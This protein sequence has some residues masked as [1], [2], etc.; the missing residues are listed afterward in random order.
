MTCTCHE[1]GAACKPNGLFA[2]YGVLK[3]GNKICYD[4]CAKR[5]EQALMALSGKDKISLYLIGKNGQEEIINWP[6]TLRIK[7]R[8]VK[9]GRHNF[10][11][12]RRDVWFAYKGK[13]FHGTQY[14]E[15]NEVC[16]IQAVA[17]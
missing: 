6:G 12:S 4:C 11:G 10:A 8:Y 1:C 3:N 5:D 16:Y 7:P 14:G 17:A 13:E 2:G 15:M 9:R